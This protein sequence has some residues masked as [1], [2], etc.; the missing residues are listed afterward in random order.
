MAKKTTT[1]IPAKKTPAKRTAAKRT[2]TKVRPMN[3]RLA[4]MT[5][6]PKADAKPAPEFTCLCGCGQ[7]TKSDF[8]QGHDMRAKSALKAKLGEKFEAALAAAGSVAALA[9]RHGF[10]GGREP[11]PATK[12]AAAK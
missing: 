4:Q 1:K 9:R 6:P 5:A 12:K 10:T 8:K 3:K 7:A 2:T 11:K